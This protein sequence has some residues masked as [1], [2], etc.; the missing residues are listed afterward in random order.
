M[1]LDGDA[2]WARS[3]DRAPFSNGFEGDAWMAA[4]CERCKL[5]PD[6]PLLTLAMMD[7]TPFAW[8]DF[9]IGGLANR[10]QCVEFEQV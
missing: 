4:W 6:C 2:E 7:R 10:Y 9:Q 8:V 5:E 1:I 3:D